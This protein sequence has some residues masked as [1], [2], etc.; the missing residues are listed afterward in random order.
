MKLLNLSNNKLTS[1]PAELGH[2]PRITV[3]F[4]CNNQLRNL[5]STFLKLSTLSA[6]WITDNQSIPLM[7]LNADFDKNG[8]LVCTNV[9]LPQSQSHDVSVR[10]Y[11]SI[12]CKCDH[13]EKNR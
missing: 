5:P 3:I 1:L 12:T 11:L 6:L 4:L 8:E 2:L 13:M 7:V 10:M 9:L